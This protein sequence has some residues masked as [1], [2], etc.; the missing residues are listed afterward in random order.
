MDEIDAAV[1]SA[2]EGLDIPVA[3]FHY[4]GGADAFAIY[5][6]L[7]DASVN[8]ADDDEIERELSYRV[9]LFSRGNY[10]P[11]VDKAIQAI[12]SV[13]GYGIEAGPELYERDTGYHHMPIDF[14][15]MQELEEEQ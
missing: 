9:D 4:D 1:K 13:G 7:L 3:R 6:L 15:I 12:K 2:M 5:Q 14:S 8:H 10:L 11:L